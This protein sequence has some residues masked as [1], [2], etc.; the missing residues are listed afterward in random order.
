[1]INQKSPYFLCHLGRLSEIVAAFSLSSPM[2]PCSLPD[3]IIQWDV[4]TRSRC[5]LELV[6]PVLWHRVDFSTG[7]HYTSKSL[8]LYFNDFFFFLP[9]PS[10]FLVSWFSKEVRHFSRNRKS[11]P[12]FSQKVH[13]QRH[14]VLGLGRRSSLQWVWGLWC[15]GELLL[16][17]FTDVQT[18][19]KTITMHFVS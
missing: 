7:E 18:W 9:R 4:W 3:S 11:F 19:Y 15:Y 10:P 17:R 8:A 14:S 13:W 1:M 12:D 6:H 2:T 16:S 5:T